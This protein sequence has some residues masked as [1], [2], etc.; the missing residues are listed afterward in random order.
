MLPLALAGLSYC[1]GTFQ[2]VGAVD[3]V[4]APNGFKGTSAFSLLGACM[5]CNASTT[6]VSRAPA[7]VH[8]CAVVMVLA[9]NRCCRLHNCAYGVF[10]IMYT[11]HM[12]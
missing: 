9:L 10:H 12:L 7:F 8:K 4:Q 2:A 5:E 1:E 6:A 11:A 3:T